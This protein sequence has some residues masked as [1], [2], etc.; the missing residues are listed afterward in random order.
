MQVYD[1]VERENKVLV[2]A[3][4]YRGDAMTLLAFDLD[5]S[6]LEGFA[7]FSVQVGQGERAPYYLLNKLTF[8]DAV[9]AKS[10]IDK[11]GAGSTLYSP[12]QKFRW[13]HVPSQEHYVGKPYFGMYTYHITPRYLKDGVLLPPDPRLTVHLKIEVS[14][15][16]DEDIQVG[17]T[18]AFVSSQAYALQFGNNTKMRPN[19][20][21]LIFD[22]TQVSGQALRWDDSLHA[23]KEVP[24]TFEEQFKYLGWQA[25][26][27]IM[28]FLDEAL[29]KRSIRLD[30][31]AFDLDDPMIVQK[32]F[33]L[34][35]QGRLRIILD[36][37]DTPHGPPTTR[38]CSRR[39][40]P[41]RQRLAALHRGHFKSLA[42]SKVF[43]QRSKKTGK[44]I[45][46]L[47]GSTNFTTSGIYINAN[48]VLIFNNRKAAQLYAQ[49]FDLAFGDQLMNVFRDT[50]LAC[51]DQLVKEARLPD[52]TIRFSPH[53]KAV[54]AK[55]F[56]LISE[57]I[58]Q[59][60]SDV[61]FA[62][63]DDDSNS[64]ILDAV[65][66]QVKSD[67]VF[68]YGITDN[69]SNTYLYKPDSK[70]GIKVSG[71]GTE[72]A[73]PPPFNAVAKVPGHS[74]HHKFIVVDFKGKQGVVYCGS[75]NLAFDP[76][77][78]NGDNLIEIRDEDVVTA[79]AVEAIRLVDHF[80]WRN[81]ARTAEVSGTP[82]RLNDLSD[83]EK[84]WYRSYYDARD[85]HYLERTLLVRENL[86]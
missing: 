15:F 33:T 11:K 38:P 57:R 84:I 45:K 1:C 56:N 9:L 19:N 65:Q 43:I 37:S 79:F 41:P 59:A 10:N 2:A 47:T 27:R 36:N 75:S 35:K 55:F 13:V 32:L 70:T 73:L 3:R 49:A 76:E 86:K 29:K 48:H 64:S 22:V 66:A 30:V 5:G 67:K 39:S 68:T 60:E 6:M 12:I 31:F 40:S 54:A 20:T 71:R 44:G 26:D 53:K 78:K 77:Q 74:I 51:N 42:H 17:F 24:Y 52:M 16:C 4:A 83:P 14:P 21:D 85:L 80:Q 62:I 58:R 50:D 46:V 8:P 7:G 25:R 69:T 82:V 72:T 81:K 28:E 23:Q 18:R 34:A 61:L 63:M